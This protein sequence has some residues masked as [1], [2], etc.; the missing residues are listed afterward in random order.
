M[1]ATGANAVA[2][3]VTWYQ[4]G[5]RANTMAPDPQRTPDDAA[6]AAIVQRAHAAGLRVLLRPIVDST[7]GRWRG[8]FAPRDVRAWFRSYDTMVAHY[9]GLARSLGVESFAV[10]DEFKS[11]SGHEARWRAIVATTRARFGGEVGYSANWDEYRAVRWWDAV[12]TIGV[13]AYFPLSAGP[14]SSTAA[15]VSRWSRFTDAAG[16]RHDY[17]GELQAVAARYRRPI[18]FTEIGYRS[19]RRTLADPWATGGSFDAAAQQRA[20]QAAFSAVGDR[21]WLRGMYIWNWHA[22]PS[23]GG[24]A[25]TAHLV[26]GKPAERTVTQLF[27]RAAVARRA[28]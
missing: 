7:D 14:L 28:G 20:L 15:I 8:S 18:V 16:A 25:D 26:Q 9:A 4:R 23:R 5:I 17:L 2:V 21:S 19:A 12:D 11:L 27:T 1:A 22:D 6:V 10:G 3:P 13:D 24:M